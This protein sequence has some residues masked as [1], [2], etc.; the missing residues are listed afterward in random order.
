MKKKF[1]RML[2]LLLTAA[3]LVAGVGIMPAQEVEAAARACKR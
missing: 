1:S 3:M 2:A